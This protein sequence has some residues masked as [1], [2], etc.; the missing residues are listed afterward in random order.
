MAANALKKI[1]TAAKKLRKR[2]PGMSWKSAVKKAG[3]MFRAG[4]LKAKKKRVASV[5][6]V[7]R[8]KKAT[9]KKSTRRAVSVRAVRGVRV[10]MPVK[11]KRRRVARKKTATRRRVGAQGGK[12]K[13]VQTLLIGGLAVGL[14]VAFTRQRQTQP[15]YYP[16]GDNYRDSRAQQ[17]IAYA[18]AAGLA[19]TQIAALINTINQSSD[20]QLDTM[21]SDVQSG[22]I[23]P[24]LYA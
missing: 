6:A 4:K 18:T 19:A 13:L 11:R 8:K 17:I 5:G 10:A 7:K 12:D 24:Y 20:A 21:N 9:R 22:N 14:I 3:S 23:Q 2:A 15:A 1:T 16:T